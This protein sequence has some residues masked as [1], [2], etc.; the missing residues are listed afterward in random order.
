MIVSAKRWHCDVIA[1]QLRL[2]T[3]AGLER[4]GL[5]PS[6]VMRRFFDESYKCFT[7]M[8][9]S[10]P[11]V[12]TGV[13]GSLLSPEG[14]V[15]AAVTD[16]ATRYPVTVVRALQRCGDEF[17]VGKDELVTT[18]VDGDDKAMKLAIFLGGAVS[19]RG[20]GS[21][22]IS[23]QGRATLRSFIEDEPELHWRRGDASVVYMRSAGAI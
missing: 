18:I 12:M 3:V 20:F 4:M 22:A 7:L 2:E 13:T 16:R 10:E 17:F 14:F 11:A 21:Q 15:W 23:R 6:D 19:R 9:E 8:I 1:T 5:T